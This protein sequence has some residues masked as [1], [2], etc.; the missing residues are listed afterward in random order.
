[1]NNY[2]LAT[3]EKALRKIDIIKPT[4][5]VKRNGE[6]WNKYI[7]LLSSSVKNALEGSKDL[8]RFFEENSDIFKR[9]PT[10]KQILKEYPNLIQ[11]L[12]TTVI[13]H[14]DEL[15]DVLQ[16]FISKAMRL[17]T[18]GTRPILKKNKQNFDEV[19]LGKITG[20]ESEESY[21]SDASNSYNYE[22]I[23]GTQKKKKPKKINTKI[24]LDDHINKVYQGSFIDVEDIPR[25]RM[26]LKEEENW[27]N[28]NKFL[29]DTDNPKNMFNF[30]L[31]QK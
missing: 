27:N 5:L 10:Q 16:N 28:K 6:S 8:K 25:R 11:T 4:E 7:S 9:H 29:M 21:E 19:K 13:R 26:T 12:K 3:K 2:S 17:K 15:F 30:Y 1:M 22:D 23:F 31:N 14:P 24:S 18:I 20:N